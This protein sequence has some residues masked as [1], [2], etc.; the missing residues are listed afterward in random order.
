MGQV[1]NLVNILFVRSWANTADPAI[2][3]FNDQ[4][5]KLDA[6]WKAGEIDDRLYMEMLQQSEMLKVAR[7][8]EVKDDVEQGLETSFVIGNAIV[9][10]GWLPLG[11]EFA[12]KQNVIPGLLGTFG[13]AGIAWL[14][15]WR[16][17]QTTLRLYTGQ[18]TA[19]K[20]GA[21]SAIDT[22]VPAVKESASAPRLN[23]LEWRLPWVS[24][25]TAAVALGGF[26]SLI[27]A[28]EAKMMLLT[29][30]IMLVVFGSL[31]MSN[32]F[33]SK[34]SKE[35]PE[36][37]QPFTM[38]EFVSPLIAY[39]AMSMSLL[40]IGQF[41]GNQFGFDRGGFRALVLSAAAAPPDSPGKEPGIC[42]AG[43]GACIACNHSGGGGLP[44][45]NRR[46]SS[47]SA[48]IAVDVHALLHGGKL[49]VDHCPH[50]NPCRDDE[51]CK[52]K[53]CHGHAS[54]GF[55]DV[56]S[57]GIHARVAPASGAF[58]GR[59][60][61]R[62]PVFAGRPWVIRFVVRTC[63]FLVSVGVEVGGPVTCEG[64]S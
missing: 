41:V 50:A 26:R 9:P 47:G 31:F 32:A 29:P 60:S 6:A 34:G 25:P 5:E 10:P 3:V 22:T 28:P 56:V 58:A 57:G 24:E 62:D 38:P 61:G 2:T 35:S 18:F 1:P 7:Q 4:Q 59:R 54:R 13:F 39:G 23:L 11:A 33:T 17:Y 52:C 51:A 37:M 14:S 44:G 15:L 43:I 49:A 42:A 48:A 36:W 12:A 63:L 55:S 19:G 46:L 21:V 64:A 53:S 8:R 40:S 16:A 20:K 30:V 45:A 27:R